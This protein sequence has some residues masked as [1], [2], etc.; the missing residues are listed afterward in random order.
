MCTYVHRVSRD[1]AI[2]FEKVAK[3]PH[4]PLRRRGRSAKIS[5]RADE[6]VALL[7]SSWI[8]RFLPNSWRRDRSSSIHFRGSN[9]FHGVLSRR[10]KLRVIEI[11]GNRCTASSRFTLPLTPRTVNNVS[12]SPT[13]SIYPRNLFPSRNIFSYPIFSRVLI[14][15]LPSNPLLPS[16][17]RTFAVP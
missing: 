10:R 2:A 14:P 11:T 5:S 8:S 4:V 6:C 9:Y 1:N 17:L 12:C 15:I 7:P 16:I 3:F 13:P